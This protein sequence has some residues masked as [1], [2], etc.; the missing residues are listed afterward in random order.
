MLYS[1][2]REATASKPTDSVSEVFLSTSEES[3]SI[4]TNMAE[5][6]SQPTN[7]DLMECMRDIRQRLVTM[8]TKLGRIEMLEKKVEGFEKE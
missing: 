6:G 4:V 5:G 1:E 8:E 2:D 3:A 7:K